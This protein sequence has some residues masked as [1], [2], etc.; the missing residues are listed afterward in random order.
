MNLN[1]EGGGL[2]RQQQSVEQ[3]QHRQESRRVRN[4]TVEK[5]TADLKTTLDLCCCL[6]YADKAKL[7]NSAMITEACPTEF[8]PQLANVTDMMV[9]CSKCNIQITKSQ[10]PTCAF[11]NDLLPDD[12][13]IELAVLTPDE[14]RAITLICPTRATR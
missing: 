6:V 7:V 10:W 3:T 14:V 11:S 12:I 8:L 4:K 5:F 9:I 13:P 2:A 1:K